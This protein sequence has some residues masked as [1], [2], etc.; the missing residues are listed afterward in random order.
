ME[1]MTH[2]QFVLSCQQNPDC[3]PEDYEEITYPHPYIEIWM[4]CCRYR[5]SEGAP[6]LP[7]PD[8]GVLEQDADLM[9][10]FDV[11]EDISKQ[12]ER[13]AEIRRHTQELARNMGFTR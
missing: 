12:R 4:L 1:K 11:L 2:Q 10:A 6:M 7:E 13:E 8:R 3:S 5:T 9:L